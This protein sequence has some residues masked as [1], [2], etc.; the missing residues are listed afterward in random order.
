MKEKLTR[1][2][3]IAGFIIIV[4]LGL[5]AGL[6]GSLG[7][8][9]LTGDSRQS[10]SDQGKI[11]GET[12][13][14][15]DSIGRKVNVPAKVERVACLYAFSG[16][17]ATM[18]GKSEN[19]VAVVDGLKRDVL[20]TDIA[21][22]IKNAAVPTNGGIIN[23]EELLKAKPD[24]VFISGDTAANEGEI[25]KLNK[26]KLPY[27]VV[28]YKNIKEQQYTIEMIGK[29]LGAEDKAKKYNDYYQAAID[30][31]QAKVKDIPIEDRVKVYHSVNE[32]ARTDTKDSLPADWL[33]QAGA[34]NV[35]LNEKLKVVEG[36]KYFASLEQILLWNPQVIL[37][38]E[39]GVTDY[40]LG[41]SQWSSIDAVKN[42]K[43]YQMPNGISRWGHPGSL[44]TPLAI[45]WTA[46]TL[47]PDRF[48]DID[49]TKE[50]K[51]FYKEFFNTSLTDDMA[52]QVLSGKGMR[53]PKG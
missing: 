5:L 35:S 52:A 41:N 20:L 11:A 31:V 42:K 17:V 7:T 34:Y 15:T 50:A 40:I 51:D 9:L 53:I 45:L 39:A 23:I 48:S 49:V 37:V 33:L 16:H 24:L 21:P 46:K 1:R 29:V 22:E 32:A 12:I 28:D 47:Y 27:L 14:V 13:Q 25:E 10:D 26:S 19:I 38:N 30:R 6:R 44:E 8:G 2:W 36:N 43:V 3:L 4:S 18:L